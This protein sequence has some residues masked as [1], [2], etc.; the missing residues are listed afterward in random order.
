MLL[1][2]LADL[3]EAD[4]QA[5]DGGLVQLGGDGGREGQAVGQL[6]EHLR[7]LA[8]AAAGGIARLLLPLLRVSAHTHT[9]RVRDTTFPPEEGVR[10]PSRRAGSLK[11]GR[12]RNPLSLTLWAAPVLVRVVGGHTG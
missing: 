10:L 5:H 9:R 6:E 1:Q 8:A 3:E 11:H 12:T 4:G 2:H 7:L